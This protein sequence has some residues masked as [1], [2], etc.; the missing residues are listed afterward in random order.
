VRVEQVPGY[1]T[2]LAIEAAVRGLRGVR[3]VVV[4]SF[5]RGT[6]TLEV[7]A[8]AWVDLPVAITSLAGLGLQFRGREDGT[9]EFAVAGLGVPAR[10]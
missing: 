1:A 4:R 5:H 9:L 2:A 10:A 7:D 6:L 3:E 8:E